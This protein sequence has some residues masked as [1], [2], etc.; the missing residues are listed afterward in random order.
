MSF[1]SRLAEE[2]KRLGFRQAEF[3]AM[4]GSDMPKQSLYE[5]DHRALRG[6]YLARA[7]AAGV[8]V[9]YVLTGQRIEAGLFGEDASALLSGYLDLP[10]ALRTEL[11]RLVAELARQVGQGTERR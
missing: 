8:D 5:N 7:A 10:S 3:A 4:V 2:R 9:I 1:G 11:A 6:A